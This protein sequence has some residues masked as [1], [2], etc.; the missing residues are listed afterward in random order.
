MTKL[1]KKWVPKTRQSPSYFNRSA[2]NLVG[3][4]KEIFTKQV[5]NFRILAHII[6]SAIIRKFRA[7]LSTTFSLF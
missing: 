6:F 4:V 5:K 2:Q 1:L 7:P 3:Q